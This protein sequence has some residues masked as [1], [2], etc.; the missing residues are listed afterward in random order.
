MK[1]KIKII[2]ISVLLFSSQIFSQQFNEK[3]KEEMDEILEDIFFNS[4]ILSAKIYDLTSDELLYQKDEKLL[5]RPASNMKV[6][7]SAAGLEFLGTEY[8]F[9]TSVYHTGIIIDSVCYGDIIV[10]GG[11]D[12]DFTSKDLDTLVMQIRKFGINEIRG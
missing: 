9:N 7:T 3:I 10:E 4:T 5:L 11:F 12:P 8:S 6:L 1:T 2:L